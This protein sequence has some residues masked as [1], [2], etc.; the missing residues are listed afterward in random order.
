[1]NERWV[2]VGAL[3]AMHAGCEV[4]NVALWLVEMGVGP[5]FCVRVRG[6]SG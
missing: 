6:C 3:W 2:I 5:R 1:M 4:R